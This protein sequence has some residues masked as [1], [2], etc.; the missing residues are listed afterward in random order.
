M[1]EIVILSGKGGTGKTSIS[2]AFATINPN[3]IVAD[4]D[5]DAANL[6]LILQPENHHENTMVTG[7]KAKIVQEKC[8]SCGI[9]ME[10]CSFN[11][12]SYNNGKYI[13]SELACD[14]CVLCWRLCSEQAI[15]L[16]PSD[17]SKWFIGDYRNGKLIHARLQPGEENSGKLVSMVRDLAKS[18]AV[19]FGIKHVIIDGPPGTA[20]PAISSVTGAAKALIVTEP[21]YS[22]FHDMKRIIDLTSSFSVKTFVLINKFDL[23]SDLSNE[24]EDWCNRNGFPVLGK[25]NFDRDIVEAMLNCKS[26]VEWKPESKTSKE[27]KKVFDYL[28]TN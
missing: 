27:I 8:T 19:N 22:G 25:I 20:C 10:F 14:G 12:I 21:T 26:I 18:L 3:T 7:H 15:E 9:C 24:I 2:A 16:I 6:H 28:I 5:V 1:N 13:I 17:K 23:N 4:C 11:A